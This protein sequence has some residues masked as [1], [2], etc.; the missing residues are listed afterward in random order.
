MR[1]PR[2][3]QPAALLGV[4]AGVLFLFSFGAL[5]DTPDTRDTASETAGWFVQHRNNVFESVFAMTLAVAALIWF[6]AALA[7]SLDGLA[8]SVVLSAGTLTAAVVLLGN[9][10]IYAALSYVIASDSP[11]AAKALF[12]MT[13]VAVNVTGIGIALLVG[14]TATMRTLPSW[15]R[16][17]SAAVAAVT[18]ASGAALRSSGPLS[19][20][21]AQQ[22]VWQAFV[23]WLI[24]VG[25]VLSRRPPSVARSAAIDP[26]T[27]R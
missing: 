12:E 10:L 4:L 15:I 3:V 9:G 24:L 23:V 19:P 16:W 22:I 20:D 13:L 6:M 18:A 2:I 25:T 26:T 14:A 7:R 27:S 1:R 11:S 21:V 5:G 8:R 17:V